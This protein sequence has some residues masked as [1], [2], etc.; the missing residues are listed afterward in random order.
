MKKAKVY[1]IT[2]KNQ[3]IRMGINEAMYTHK[4]H[5]IKGVIV[6]PFKRY[7]YSSFLSD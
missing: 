5:G 4:P 3:Q 1:I 6:R 7:T 2:V